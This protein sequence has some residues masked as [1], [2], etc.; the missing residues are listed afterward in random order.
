MKDYYVILQVS[1]YVHV[2]PL[3]LTLL[4]NPQHT[5]PPFLPPTTSHLFRP[6][7]LS[8]IHL[9]YVMIYHPLIHLF[10]LPS[11]LSPAHRSATIQDIK[12]AY[13]NFALKLHP[14]VTGKEGGREGE[15]EGR[16][17]GLPI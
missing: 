12:M 4:R 13:K 8:P 6:P 2:L 3:P 16:R 14:D 15:W 11:F 1:R 17:D 9:S 7:S 5:L 10:P